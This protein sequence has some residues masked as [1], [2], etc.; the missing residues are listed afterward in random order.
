MEQP[1]QPT[2]ST[3]AQLFR[4]TFSEAASKRNTVLKGEC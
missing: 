1:D 2:A 3:F 4:Q